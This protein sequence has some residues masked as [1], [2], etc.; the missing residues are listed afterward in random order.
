M[1]VLPDVFRC[2]DH[3]RARDRKQEGGAAD[4]EYAD[5]GAEM[6]YRQA[7]PVSQSARE[8]RKWQSVSTI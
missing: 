4:P 7:T 3:P 2:N 5:A 1:I 6:L 8:A